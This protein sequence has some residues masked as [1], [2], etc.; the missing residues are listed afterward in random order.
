MMRQFVEPSDRD[1]S[2][3][4]FSRIESTWPRMIREMYGQLNSPMIRLTRS[5][6]GLIRPP[7][8]PSAVAPHAEAS[9]S[10]SSRIGSDSTTSVSRE[11][12]VSVF[13]RKNPEMTPRTVPM[14]SEMPVAA[15]AMTS[16]VRAP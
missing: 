7:K 3:N 12:K 5:R 15:N 2:T 8:Q 14:I 1:A 4:S 9:P 10:A 6:P 13:P 16:D 11:M